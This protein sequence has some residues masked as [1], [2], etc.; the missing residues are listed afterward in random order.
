MT[1]RERYKEQL[2][3]LYAKRAILLKAGRYLDANNLN[4]DIK[5]V[6]SLIK[7][8]EEY[9]ELMRPRPIREVV[10]QEELQKMG[11]IPLMIECHL[12]ADMLVEVSYMI[13]DICKKHGLTDM[14]FMPEI[15][16]I[17]KRADKF[18]SLLAKKGPDLSDLLERNE[19]LNAALHK[20]YI[21]YIEQRLNPRKKSAK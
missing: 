19:T 14:T 17:L 12:I 1:R 10:T 15:D 9:E 21:S 7:E 2:S 8:A 3:Q 16:D 20:K 13:V 18:A 4:R 6:E 5:Y 11:I